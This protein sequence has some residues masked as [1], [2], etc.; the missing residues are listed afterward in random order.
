MQ[1]SMALRAVTGLRNRCS[2]L[3]SG[4]EKGPPCSVL[5]IPLREAAHH[6]AGGVQWSYAAP[7]ELRMPD[8]GSSSPS[9]AQA[10]ASPTFTPSTPADRMPPA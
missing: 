4:C 5:P 6:T 9:M 8:D 7:P 10:T 1:K 3:F 2:L